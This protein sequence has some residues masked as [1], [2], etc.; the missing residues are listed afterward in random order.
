MAREEGELRGDRVRREYPWHL[1]KEEDDSH[2]QRKLLLGFPLP[3]NT[4]VNL[5]DLL[6]SVKDC[7]C[8]VSPGTYQ[9]ISFLHL[10][11][12]SYAHLYRFLAYSHVGRKHPVFLKNHPPLLFVPSLL[13]I[14]WCIKRTLFTRILPNTHTSPYLSFTTIGPRLHRFSSFYAFY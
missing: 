13:S 7:I 4:L 5:V 14:A 8:G 3:C 10:G 9:S 2:K 1:P 11:E 6:G 12:V